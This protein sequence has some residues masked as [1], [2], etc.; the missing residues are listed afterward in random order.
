[1]RST[2]DIIASI[3]P[4]MAVVLHDLAMVW[5]AWLA[6]YFI[7]YS[8]SSDVNEVT[9]LNSELLIVMTVQGLVLWWTGLYKGIWR[10]ASLPDL[11]N[12]LKA[13]FIGTLVIA[14]SLVL[15]NRFVSVPRS[16]ITLYPLL[17]MLFLGAP[18]VLYRFWK[19]NRMALYGRLPR[20]RV[21]VL[22][23]GRSADMLV[24]EMLREQ[25]YRIVGFLDDNKRLHGAKLHGIPV[26][27]KISDLPKIS[28]EVM[29]D[30]VVI[31]VPSASN[32]QMQAIVEICEQTGVHFMTLPRLQDMVSGKQQAMELKEVAIEDLLGREAVK[33]DWDGIARDLSGKTIL[34]TG[35]GGSI[36]SELCRQLARIEPAKLLI[37]ENSEHNLY[38][39]DRDLRRFF[40]DLAF[41]AILGDVCDPVVC[42][43]VFS[44][45][46]PDVIFHAAAYKHVPLLEGQT[47]EAVRNN[48][49]GTRQIAD[50]ADRYNS[51]TFVLIS[52]D[53]AVNPGNV[54][55]ASKRIAE[56]YCQNLAA[57]SS[58]RFITVRFGNVLNSAG[59]VVPLF[60][61][62][63]MRGGPVTVTHPEVSRYFMSIPEACLLI[64]QS[65]IQGEGGEIFV[66]DMGEPVKIEYLAEQ[67]I[68]L[69]GKVPGQDIQIVYTGL[70]PGEKLYEELFHES[71]SCKRTPHE[72]IFLARYR[73]VDWA[74]IHGRFAELQRAVDRYDDK[75]I[76]HLIRLLVPEFTNNDNVV[77][78]IHREKNAS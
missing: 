54:M 53:K 65:A 56:I 19:D 52:T 68:R 22:G 40:P 11:L 48:I 69:A 16:V 6:A 33:L 58:T 4:R 3:H 12:I 49:L 45:H 17:L 78:H 41:H 29:A 23:A 25:Q 28:A 15:Y 60:S 30:L 73:Q 66:L 37:L 77:T 9:V 2:R 62:Q 7:R 43:R 32:E 50:F 74:S 8:F 61:E 44:S 64:M 76:S 14:L 51:E 24:R 13:C 55:G 35:G 1:M 27:G 46:H 21:L 70:R 18:R 72:K 47:R 42:E 34:V 36:G 10:F 75:A 59:S 31:S 67:M 63:I 57:H 71:E 20:Q 26:L 5:A 38:E 39:I